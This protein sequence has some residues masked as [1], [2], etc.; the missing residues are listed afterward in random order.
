MTAQQPMKMAAAE[1]LYET[2]DCASFSIF[3]IGSLDGSEEVFSIRIPYVLSFL[4]TG[5]PCGTVE[6]I[7]N[8]QAQEEAQ[9]GPGD[10]T[11]NI[12]LAYW[13]FRL[14]IGFG[15]V[16]VAVALWGLWLT[17]RGRT[18]T[19]TWWLRAVLLTLAAPYLA[20]SWGWI[21]TET[22]RQPWTVYG[23]FQT[24]DSVSPNTS[25]AEVWISL[26]SFTLLYGALLV[27]TIWLMRRTVLA[28]APDSVETG[29]TDERDHDDPDRP[30]VFAY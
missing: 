29:Y 17:R 5:T 12:P 14:M 25:S 23:L 6:G 18:P 26:I 16:A 28:G 20:N 13:S 3:T 1:A 30:L 4:A 9:F 21:F 10:Y 19:G 24:S 8:V 7:N 22:A 27:V 2:T 11:P 15:L